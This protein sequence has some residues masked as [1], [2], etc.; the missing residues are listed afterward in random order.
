MELICQIAVS[1][2]KAKIFHF[3]FNLFQKLFNLSKRKP[4]DVICTV[5]SVK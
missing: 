1:D 2:L 3:F 5:E 4:M